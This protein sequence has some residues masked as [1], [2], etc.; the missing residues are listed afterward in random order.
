[1]SDTDLVFGKTSDISLTTEKLITC[2]EE[3]RFLTEFW[4]KDILVERVFRVINLV[5]QSDS[6]DSDDEY[7][8]NPSTLKD[9]W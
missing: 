9:W 8:P 7:V 1:M 4:N 3:N 6:S 2:M 5:K